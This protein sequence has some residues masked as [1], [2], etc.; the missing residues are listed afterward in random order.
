MQTVDDE[1]V[2]DSCR[3]SM[4]VGCGYVR[5]LDGVD[6]MD[7]VVMQLAGTVSDE[8]GT[9]QAVAMA[10]ERNDG[11]WEGWLEFVPRAEDSCRY[12]TP[13][14]TRQHDRVTMERW[15]SGLTVVYAEG[16]LARARTLRPAESDQMR[17]L[18]ELIEALDRQ[19]S[20]LERAGEAKIAD[21]ARRLRAAAGERLAFLR[22]RRAD[23]VQT[24]EDKGLAK[25]CT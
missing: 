15:A 16:A 3:S 23:A 24:Y 12:A 5:R 25:T 2:S 1:V 21:D 13:I 10:R 11:G 7:V 20:H 17:A 6:D 8:R 9:F 22:D 4:L 19:V 18:H 14:E